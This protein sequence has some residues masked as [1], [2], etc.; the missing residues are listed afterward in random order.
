MTT[1]DR[2]H[3]RHPGR[4]PS[5]ALRRPRRDVAQPQAHPPDPG[6]GDLRGHPV[7]HVRAAVR[8]R[9]RRR[10][11]APGYGGPTPTAST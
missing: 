3:P 1:Q 10:H 9:V 7:D 4:Q 2:T 8:L 6:A 5:G 11:P